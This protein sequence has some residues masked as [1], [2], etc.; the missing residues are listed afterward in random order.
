MR[1]Q[2]FAFSL[3]Q[4]L[5][6]STLYT[7]QTC[8]ELV[9]SQL[10]DTAHPA[11]AQVVNIINLAN[12]ITQIDQY[13]DGVH[14][15]FIGQGHRTRGILTP[16]QAA[17]DLHPPNA[18]KVVGLFTVKETV[19]QVLDSLLGWRLTRTHHAINGNTGCHLIGSV[20]NTQEIGRAHV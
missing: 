14:D 15:V 2:V 4:P 8:S 1:H 16:P 17:I 5:T 7:H 3:R 10:S 6:Y 11:I 9:F 20:I 18:G 12:A 13:L 19:E